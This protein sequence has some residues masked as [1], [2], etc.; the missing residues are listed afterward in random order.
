[1]FHSR[2]RI[3]FVLV[4]GVALAVSAAAAPASRAAASVARSDVQ[5]V[6]LSLKAVG[7][8][9]PYFSLTLT[10]GQTVSLEVELGNHAARSMSVRTYAADAY[11]IVNGGFGV[12]GRDSRP[13]GTTG[14]VS[15]PTKV[16][17]LP[18]G[19]ASIRTFSVTVPAGTMPGQYLAGLVLENDVP[20]KGSGSVA[21]DQL[22]RQA[23]AI[24]I[25][26]PGPLNPAFRLDSASHHFV[27]G[28]SVV[29]ERV[30]NSGNA[31]LRPS[32][33][34]IIRDSSGRTVSEAPIAMGSLYSHDTTEVRSTLAG[35]L[36]PGE[37]TATVTLTDPE[38]KTTA[39]GKDLPFTVITSST[40]T[41]QGARQGELPQILQT[42][43]TSAVLYIAIA[44]L[45]VALA[46]TVTVLIVWRRRA[47]TRQTADSE[48]LSH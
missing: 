1:M 47:R 32:G 35:L 2:S 36:Q 12:K 10:P 38:T 46:G 44:A 17:E 20:V 37:Y 23:L 18:A 28:H 40:A 9:S 4:L 6:Q 7:Q 13:T 22:V 45:A 41:S 25:Q 48:R 34:V 43:G 3:A 39:T 19:E 5:P 14:W 27:A 29:G 30:A 31:H 16:L 42:D 8:S 21:L 26:V 33:R 11:S 24:S 15:Y